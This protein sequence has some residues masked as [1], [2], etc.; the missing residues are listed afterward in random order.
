M[1]DEQKEWMDNASYYTL[2]DK[3]R[4][5]PVGDKVFIGEAGKY[6]ADAMN[7]VKYKLT[8]NEQVAVSKAVD[9]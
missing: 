8:H 9:R 3:W 6:Y 7:K 4:N 1:T 2:L 5:A